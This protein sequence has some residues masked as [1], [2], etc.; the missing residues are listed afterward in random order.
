LLRFSNEK[1]IFANF[2]FDFGNFFGSEIC[3]RSYIA[4]Y[5]G[6]ERLFW[7][8]FHS[9]LADFN[10]HWSCFGVDQFFH[11]ANFKFNN[12]AL[13]NFNIWTFFFNN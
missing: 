4:C 7:N 11:K 8:K 12:F 3:P 9:R 1:I 5:S 13:E 2:S 10:F 6:E